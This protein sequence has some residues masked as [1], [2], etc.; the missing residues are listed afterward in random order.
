MKHIGIG[1]AL[2]FSMVGADGGKLCTD[3]YTEAVFPKRE[4]VLQSVSLN[5]VILDPKVAETFS[6][7]LPQ[8]YPNPYLV[9][10]FQRFAKTFIAEEEADSKDSITAFWLTDTILLERVRLVKQH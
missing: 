4:I 7:H 3:S 5:G 8:N 2:L 1:T 6:I 9:Q 10:P